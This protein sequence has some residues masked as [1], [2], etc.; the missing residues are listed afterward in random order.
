MMYNI[1]QVAII[2]HEFWKYIL[3]RCLWFMRM[4]IQ[5]EFCA[6]KVLLGLENLSTLQK[7]NVST[8]GGFISNCVSIGTIL[9]VQIRQVTITGR[10][11]LRAVQL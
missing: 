10:C 8:F 2:L 4:Q 11:L 1:M 7:S 3:W 9:S 5:S 6:F